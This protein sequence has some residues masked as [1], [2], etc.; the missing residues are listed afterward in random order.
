VF[1]SVFFQTVTNDSP[2]NAYRVAL[3]VQAGLLIAFI[4]LSFLF[5]KKGKPEG[6][7]ADE[8]EVDARPEVSAS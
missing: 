6:G 8:S 2:S 5:P 1:G 4:A 7:V 3:L